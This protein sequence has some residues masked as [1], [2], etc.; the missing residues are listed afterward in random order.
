MT[1]EI[2]NIML[3]QIREIDER[4][5]NQIVAELAGQSIEEYIYEITD[6][7]SKKR[8]VKL[9]WIG[10]REMARY[11]GNISVSDPIITDADGYVRIVVK[12]TDLKRNFSVFGGTHQ[13]K[14]QKVKIF[15]E[16]GEQLGYEDQDDPHYF[17][18]ALSKAQRNVFQAVI[19]ADFAARMIDRFLTMA[20]REPLKQLPK[21]KPASKPRLNPVVPEPTEL[22]NLSQLEVYAFNRWHIQPA[23]MYQQLN[24]QNRN[25]CAV[26]PFEAFIALKAIY[27]P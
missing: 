26:P 7:K 19:P 11:R 21:P 12:A 24:C 1:Q 9:S 8:T 18:K 16:A 13:P 14:R 23:E 22:K 2:T 17:T 15:D 4:D 25:S 3:N 5:E 27:E 10:T 6:K 20:G